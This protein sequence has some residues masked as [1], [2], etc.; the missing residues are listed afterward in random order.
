MKPQ[1]MS[2]STQIDNK[3]LISASSNCNSVYCSHLCLHAQLITAPPPTPLFFL[4]SLASFSRSVLPGRQ[5]PPPNKRENERF[6]E[7]KSST[8][9]GK[10]L[11]APRNKVR[12]NCRGLMS[13]RTN[14]LLISLL[15]ARTCIP[16]AASVA[17]LSSTTN[18]LKKGFV[19]KKKY[20]FKNLQVYFH[21]I[22]KR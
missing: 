15:L 13:L 1:S 7:T 5:H 19:V 3:E 20:F 10:L 6:R 11:S 18:P 12:S 8:S 9:T 22:T 14:G 2:T 17:Q 4:H 21:K 16:P